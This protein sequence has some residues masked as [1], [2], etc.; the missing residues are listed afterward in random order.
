[1]DRHKKSGFT[2]AEML[3]VIVIVAILTTIA[4]PSYQA[5]IRQS[6]RSEAIAALIEIRLKEEWWRANNPTYGTLSSIGA[7]S[8][9]SF[10]NFSVTDPPQGN[11]YTITAA[12]KTGTD[13]VNDSESGTDCSTLTINQSG[14]KTPLVCWK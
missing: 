14:S 6:Q 13:Q 12:A 3:I 5:A 7:T 9:N 1:M 4:L 10:Y 11:T 2:L 8:S